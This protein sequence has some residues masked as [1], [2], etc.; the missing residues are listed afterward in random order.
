MHYFCCMETLDWLQKII[1]SGNLC[2]EYTHK[3]EFAK[4]KKQIADVA[5]DYNGAS[6]LCEMQE[7]G[8][9]LNYRVIK[10]EFAPFINGKYISENITKSGAKY[11]VSIWC[12]CEDYEVEVN[13]T[14]ATFLGCELDVV[15]PK[16]KCV[17]IFADAKC[18]IR[19]FCMDNASCNV[20]YWGEAQVENPK[21]NNK[22]KIKKRNG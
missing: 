13:T 20:Y 21:N 1:K 4:S 17:I 5:F 3:V 15:I 9:P 16:N 2:E 22:I 6:F 12:E 14:V 8:M 7:R 19:I 10:K 11:S 18:K